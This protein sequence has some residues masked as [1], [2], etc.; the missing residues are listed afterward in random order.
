MISNS[1]DMDL[2][3]KQAGGCGSEADKISEATSSTSS[4]QWSAFRN[5]RIVRV[6]R[7]F[8]G[9]DRHSKV[10]TV[11]GLRDR[12]IR[13]SVPTAIQLY[14]LQ[15]RLGLS[16]P[17][18]VIDWLLDATKTDI[19][20]LPPLQM[21]PGFGQFHQPVLFSHQSNI[22]SP[23]FDPNSTF[24][25][26]VGYNSLG[27]KID[28]GTAGLDGQVQNSSTTM[29]RSSYSRDIEASIR[30]KSKQD[31][32]ITEKGKSIKTNED[33]EIGS[34]SS[35]GQVPAQN[36]FPSANRSTIPSLLYNSTVPFNSYHWDASNLSLSTQ[37]GS[38]GFISQTENSLDTPSSLPLSSGS[39]LFFCPPPPMPS[40]F[41]SYR[42]CVITPSENESRDMNHFQLLSSS[43][44]QHILPISL[45]MNSTTKPFSLNLNPGL[46]RLQKNNES[47]PDEDDAE[48]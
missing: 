22:A 28:T 5:P 30:A 8:G 15:D 9:K 32:T 45:T 35:T 48:S 19:D 23:F 43:S 44:S 2:Q 25:K 18:K 13:L 36:F 10:C 17:S 37:F 7:S 20:K 39:Q 31:G 34:Y 40:L 14:D 6:S 3:G 29:P 11:R 42:P 1:E 26:D 41:P 27:I 47:N 21:P 4:R 38:H 12:R 46:L 16:Q 33:G 24:I